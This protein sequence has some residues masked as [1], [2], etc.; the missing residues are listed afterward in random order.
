MEYKQICK[1][2]CGTEQGTGFSISEDKII[3]ASHVILPFLNGSN[4]LE[5]V[6]AVF[7]EKEYVVTPV[8]EN[9]YHCAVAVLTA[10]E[11]IPYVKQQ[12]SCE[13][14]SESDIVTSLG[15][16][17]GSDESIR[18]KFEV[19]RLLEQEDPDKENSNVI[20]CP[21]AAER[22]DNFQ[23]LS[24][25]PVLSKGFV[26]GIML[27]QKSENSRAFRLYAIC[28]LKFRECIREQGVVVE[29]TPLVGNQS[30]TE[31]SNLRL[32]PTISAEIDKLWSRQFEPIRNERINGHVVESWSQFQQFLH[33]FSESQC[34]STQK[35]VFYYN[36]A[37]WALSDGKQKDA[38]KYLKQA[39]MENPDIDI[40]T[41]RA[42]ELI[43]VGDTA[44]A[45]KQLT[46]VET[47]AALNLLMLCYLKDKVS[48]AHA[49]ETCSI[50]KVELDSETERMLAMISLNMDEYAAAH[51]HIEKSSQMPHSEVSLWMS[52]ALIFYW[53]AMRTVYPENERLGFICSEKRHFTPT[54]IQREHLEKAYS[55]LE[56]AHTQTAISRA[57][58]MG[59]QVLWGLIIVS[60]LLPGYD[61]NRWIGELI[62]INGTLPSAILF[63]SDWGIKIP[64][65]VQAQ[66]LES[67]IP[68]ENTGIYLLAVLQLYLNGKQYDKA[69]KLFDESGAAIAE[70]QNADYDICKLQLLIDC[71][72]LKQAQRLL[73]KVKIPA[74]IKERFLIGI[75]FKA[76]NGHIKELT[77]QAVTLAQKTK[78]A[79]D[80]ENANLICQKAKKWLL[81]ERNAKQW[82]QSTGELY[83]LECVAES[84]EKQ[85][86]YPKALHTIQRA[87]LLGDNSEIIRQ[88][89]LNCLA[90]MSQFDEA[91]ELSRTFDNCRSNAKLVGFQARIF[92]A[93]G[94]KDHAVNILQTF[95][96]EGQIDFEIFKMI[97]GLIQTDEP[98]MAFQYACQLYKCDPQ[99]E[100]YLRFA[101]MTGI[102]TGHSE[103]VDQFTPLFKADAKAKKYIRTAT[104]DE[105]KTILE[106]DKKNNQNIEDL[107]DA[108]NIP[109]HLAGD[110][111][112][113][114]NLG[115]MY[116][117]MWDS[118]HILFANYG[119]R[120]T[121]DLPDRVRGVILDYT[122]C[123]TLTALELFPAVLNFFSKIWIPSNLFNVWLSDINKIKPIQS[124]L[125]KRNEELFHLLGEINYI[126]E[127][128]FDKFYVMKESPYNA[129][130]VIYAEC[131][132]KYGA[133]IIDDTPSGVITNERTPEEWYTWQVRPDE[134]YA[135]LEE[136]ELPH[137]PY[138]REKINPEK[139]KKLKE[140]CGIVPDAQV[141]NALFEV[142]VLKPVSEIFRI[143]LPETVVTTIKNSV[144][145]NHWRIDTADWLTK[146][147]N[148]LTELCKQGHIKISPSTCPS[149][150]ERFQYANLLIEEIR[151]ASQWECAV[152]CDDRFSTSY[153]QIVGKRGRSGVAISTA[154]LLNI[155][156]DHGAIEKAAFY[157]KLDMLLQ[158]T[159]CFLIPTTEYV[160]SRLALCNIDENE[161]L[162]ENSALESLR[163]N[164]AIA[165]ST[166]YG[167]L[168]QPLHNAAITEYAGYVLNLSHTFSESLYLVWTSE[169]S[170]QWKRAAA[171]WLLMVMGD[172]LCDTTKSNVNLAD[173]IPIKQATLIANG[174]RFAA[175]KIALKH[176]LEWVF[177]YLCASWINH[178]ELKAKTID[179]TYQFLESVDEGW[180][181]PVD[182][183]PKLWDALCNNFL[184][185]FLS[186]L[187]ADF[188][189]LLLKKP[190]MQKFA[191]HVMIHRRVRILGEAKEKRVKSEIVFIP[192]DSLLSGDE[193]QME[194]AILDLINEPVENG[195]HILEFFSEENMRRVDKDKRYRVARFMHDLSIYLPLTEQHIAQEKK[196][197]LALLRD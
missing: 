124:H 166:Q 48:I 190:K 44:A 3:T 64:E 187:P 155:L 32:A 16:Q 191:K 125:V 2:L 171:D 80:Y 146:G 63:M 137:P 71:N 61:P 5:V 36:A 43:Q 95:I 153:T 15:Y 33:E 40:R 56:H 156:Y 87:E 96:D 14:L 73:S 75:D 8:S 47:T 52:D 180:E 168:A 90:G 165:L 54:S 140:Y 92:L 186:E 51:Q 21:D 66:V 152:L 160:L 109:I 181:I 78:A 37:M 11:K 6:K 45:R 127:P 7:D 12:F 116:Y 192:N 159:Y 23:G 86:K 136:M 19:N 149:Q 83:A 68:D 115:A 133:C 4:S 20:L 161:K 42:Y 50:C 197:Y 77:K 39:Q 72:E 58:P 123:L 184:L 194:L 38:K 169:K 179:R 121:P 97:V 195:T 118:N 103:L 132:K 188:L 105:V 157:Q 10:K 89:K 27:R 82:F 91:I 69:I 176:Y 120:K 79:I 122:A 113:N 111:F 65:N 76:G 41:Y 164:V 138:N 128:E 17:N 162:V 154:D 99:N 49:E 84:Q 1:I 62:S 130:D 24:G 182:Q 126:C 150:P 59:V 151:N 29:V 163:R 74:E 143:V 175:V 144:D 167:V 141:L 185:T 28:G 142:N 94:Q 112:T 67:D 174:I 88:I 13:E 119:G 183:N 170:E 53:E 158:H 178:A 102:M 107:Y 147:Y 135:A 55:L 18:Y 9:C 30:I 35:A 189:E 145:E 177:S 110:G 46:P 70:A 60:V 172:T 114:G 173:W 101:G 129:M 134:L 85:L 117:N 93:S 100:D 22:T 25:A 148:L 106:E 193:D 81:V 139:I 34:S 108:V 131:A 31:K 57:N 26:S 104:L 196:R 98:D